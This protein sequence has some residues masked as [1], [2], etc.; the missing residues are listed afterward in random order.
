MDQ[1]RV[2]ADDAPVRG[3]HHRPLVEVAVVVRGCSA[4]RPRPRCGACPPAIPGA[5]ARARAPA[6]W[7]RPAS[8]PRRRA[9]PRATPDAGTTHESRGRGRWGMPPTRDGPRARPRPGPAGGRNR[10][11]CLA[12]RKVAGPGPRGA[13]GG[14]AGESGGSRETLSSGTPPG[15][16]IP[17]CARVSPC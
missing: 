15:P 16:M 9:A 13:P 7:S 5:P 14:R 12:R 2:A 10:L 11:A 17:V 4:S 6:P 8:R 3:E 1:V